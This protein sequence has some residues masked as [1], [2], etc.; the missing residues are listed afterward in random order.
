MKN[1][2]IYAPYNIKTLSTSINNETVWYSNKWKNLFL[3]IKRF[4][5]KSE[6][7]KNSE[8]YLNKKVNRSFY[9]TF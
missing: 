4:F 1:G 6:N 5:Y 9:S 8:K 2:L 3:K 7:L